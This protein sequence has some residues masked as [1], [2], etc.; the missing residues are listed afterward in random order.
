MEPLETLP[1][2]EDPFVAAAASVL[3]D[4]G[5]WAYVLDAQWRIAFVTDELRLSFGDT[6]AAHTPMAISEAPA[7]HPF[8]D[9]VTAT[10]WPDNQCERAP[11]PREAPDGSPVGVLGLAGE[12]REGT[13]TW[14]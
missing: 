7:G 12:M 11:K 4:A 8:S 1:L 5:H 2:P 6:G 10:R 13:I 14:A 3:N 9:P